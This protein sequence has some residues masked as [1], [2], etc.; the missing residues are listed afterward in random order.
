MPSRPGTDP[1][2]P[3]SRASPGRPPPTRGLALRMGIALGAV[4]AAIL[5][6]AGAW[7]L[8]VQRR[9]LTR[10]VGG[11]AERIAET[12]RRSTRDAMLRND[13]DD[14]HRMIAVI[15]AQSGIARIRVFNKEGR[16]QTSTDPQ[17][18][19][20]LV[21]KRAEQCDACHQTDKPLVRLEG[22]D[23][24][25]V[26]RGGNGSRVLGVIAPIHN[27]PQCQGPCH[28]HPPQKQVLGVLDVQLSMA[29]ADE[30]LRAS[31]RQM[32]SGLGASM[33]ALLLAGGFLVWRLVLRPVRRLT[34]A[35]TRVTRGETAT[36][37]PVTSSDEIGLMSA[38][39]NA[40]TDELARARVE[41]EAWNRS[42][43][44]RVEEKTA[45]LERAHQRMQVVDR[46]ASLGK[47]AAVVAHEINNPLA[48]I[49]T[50]A[51][52]LLRRLREAGATPAAGD[53]ER[54]LELIDGESGRCGDIVGRLLA[55]ARRS[56][57]PFAEAALAPV[58]ERC[59]ALL[60]H[61]AQMAGVELQVEAEAGLPPLRC[62]PGE[63]EQLLLA[64]AINGIEATPAG[65]R[66][67][68]TARRDG[69]ELLL[70]V[71]DTG[72]GIPE[73][74]RDHIF[75]PFFTTK[76]HGKGVGLG[77]AVVYG[78]VER[79]RGRI[80]VESREG[81]G[82][83]FAIHIPLRPAPAADGTEAT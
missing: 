8:R 71:S 2:Q 81:A 44:Q 52:L 65:G 7:N 34:A 17:E 54:I 83:R 3:P 9:E 36:P 77:L 80:E 33:A 78:I 58:L 68:L 57:A 74:I 47:L 41:I 37:I 19:G 32:L 62:D 22:P 29:G 4:C 49:R 12:I 11:S 75:E 38:S 39:W 72:A 61:S 56:P 46:M 26:F 76:E 64:L 82:T 21:D 48:G 59:R 27:E 50:Y 35:M 24:V 79:H 25:R 43:E 16:V 53:E 10:L 28:A 67:A 40:M 31:E 14:L 30:A 15:G 55:F 45:E 63:I 13:R 5:P 69:D 42:L 18:V 60:Q 66:V 1:A 23:R 6:A 20:R 73:G 51:R 70:A